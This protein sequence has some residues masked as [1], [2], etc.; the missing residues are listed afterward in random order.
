MKI[1]KRHKTLPRR[2]Q[3][4]AQLGQ[5][6]QSNTSLHR[7]VGGIATRGFLRYFSMAME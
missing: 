2:V 7:R 1:A 3:Q 4:G 5:I 6:T